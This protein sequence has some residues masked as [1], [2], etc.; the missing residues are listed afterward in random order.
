MSFAS[1]NK[2]TETIGLDSFGTLNRKTSVDALV[3]Q[4]RWLWRLWYVGILGVSIVVAFLMLV[5]GPSPQILGWI[6]FF[7]G[8]IVIILQPRYGIY[9]VAFFT[10][11]GDFRLIP[12]FPFIK[13]FSS[14][15]SLLFLHNSVIFSPLEVYLVLILVSWLGR[16][17]MQRKN[18]LYFSP[19]FWPN[20]IFIVFIAFGLFYGVGR[21]G[22]FNIAL[23]ES[24]AIFYLPL[25]MF[26]TSNL[27]VKREHL[28]NLMWFVMA[29]LF[30]EAVV[31]CHF[32]FFV[33]GAD[34]SG[35]D[36]I[37][38]HAAAVQINTFFVYLIAVWIF[39]ASVTKRLILPL[40]VPFFLITY[41]AMQ[42]RSAFVTLVLAAV[43]IAVILFKENRKAFFMIVPVIGMVALVY[44]GVFWN[45][46]GA[47]GMPAQAVKSVVAPDQAKA[48]DQASDIYRLVEN[49]NASFNIHQSPLIG[50]GFGQKISFVI[51]LPDISG[52]VFWE[53]ILHNSIVWIWIKTGFF[54]FYSLLFLIGASI[55]SGVT[56]VLKVKDPN[57]KAIVFTAT[58]YVIMHFTYAYVDMSW[59]IESMVYMGIMIGI[60]ACVERI[61]EKPVDVK[62][63]RWPWQVTP[64]PPSRLL[65][66]INNK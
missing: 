41:I 19:L 66:L 18:D 42:R 15:E 7:I 22:S 34:L 27:I 47:L 24:R 35:V 50:S 30:I 65:P 62:K 58:A 56:A 20:F 43:F 1:T 9:M 3:S 45:S 53:Y 37:A 13:N 14:S 36:R 63:A 57:L 17:I 31:G 59:D 32:Y 4:S 40:M 21:G 51:T 11:V 29:A 46:S 10:L 48:E 16:N 25:M 8:A 52:F 2:F 55:M 26:L 61:D 12:W 5:G 44:L 39:R 60:I 38:A 54:G 28:N 49:F 33:L 23:W 6:V 64:E